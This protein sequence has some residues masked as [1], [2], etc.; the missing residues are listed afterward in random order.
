M[1]YG[2][3]RIGAARRGYVST[4]AAAGTAVSAPDRCTRPRGERRM[5]DRS[6]KQIKKYTISET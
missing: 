6:E 3:L 5:H 1:N 2:L 4:T